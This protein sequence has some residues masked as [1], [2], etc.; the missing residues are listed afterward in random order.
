[1]LNTLDFDAKYDAY[2]NLKDKID[3]YEI[4]ASGAKPEKVFVLQGCFGLWMFC[5]LWE[6]I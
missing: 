4:L 5:V 3:V 1:M 6:Y 2:D